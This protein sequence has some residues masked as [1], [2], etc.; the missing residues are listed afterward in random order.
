MSVEAISALSSIES[1]VQDKSIFAG[2]N[3]TDSFTQALNRE[4]GQIDQQIHRADQAVRQLAVGEA[5][6]LHQVML[7]ITKAQTSFELAVQVRNRMVDGVKEMM[8][9]SI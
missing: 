7:A 1:S 4:L 8:R 5:D 9:M 6:N 3:I 2:N